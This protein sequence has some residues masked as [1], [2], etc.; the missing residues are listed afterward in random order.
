MTLEMRNYF[1]PS[2]SS[3]AHFQLKFFKKLARG[4][5]RNSIS[6]FFFHII[7]YKAPDLDIQFYFQKNLSH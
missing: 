1:Y 2:F 3:W 6:P 7:R 4:S 5:R